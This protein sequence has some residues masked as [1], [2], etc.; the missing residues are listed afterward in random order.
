M[1]SVPGIVDQ[2]DF[3]NQYNTP[4]PSNR[5]QE[6]NNWV[7]MM[8]QKTGRD[9]LNDRYDYDVNGL[10][11][12]GQ[13]LDDRGHATDQFKKPNHITFSDQSIYHGK[14]GNYGG[15]WLEHPNPKDVKKPISSYQPSVTNLRFHS[16]QKMQSYFTAYE[17]DTMFLPPPAKPPLPEGLK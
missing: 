2:N 1:S 17:P 10:F 14:D 3:S 6:F 7:N 8:K 9:P 4:I 5:M 15:S 12:S 13:G 16:P 11:L